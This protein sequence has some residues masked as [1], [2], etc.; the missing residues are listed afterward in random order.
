[1]NFTG[2]QDKENPKSRQVSNMLEGTPERKVQQDGGSFS[3]GLGY[4]LVIFIDFVLMEDSSL[5]S[6]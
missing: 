4:Y 1:M 2:V 6:Q 5:L 3:V